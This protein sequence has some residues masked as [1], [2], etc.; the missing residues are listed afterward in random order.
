M[1]GNRWR[2]K[3]LHDIKFKIPE[4]NAE[5]TIS[6]TRPELLPACVAITAHPD[7]VRYKSFFAALAASL[8]SAKSILIPFF[9]ISSNCE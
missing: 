9:K 4:M 5:F 8:G 7:D 6:T 2:T 3:Y 1:C